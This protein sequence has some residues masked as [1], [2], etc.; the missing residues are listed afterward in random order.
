MH[1][2][3]SVN[4]GRWRYLLSMGAGG[5]LALAYPDYNISPA[6]WVAVGGL[7]YCA[8]GARVIQ[9]SACGLL[10]GL[11]YY[12]LS[13]PWIYTVLREYGPVPPVLSALLL[14]LLSLAAALFCAAFGALVAWIARRNTN[15]ALLA[16]PFLWVTLEFARTNLPDIGFPWNL[17]GYVAS[18]NLVLLQITSVTGIFGLSLLVGAYNSLFAWLLVSRGGETANVQ[19]PVAWKKG[20]ETRVPALIVWICATGALVATSFAGPLVPTE[21]PT[22]VAQL[23]Q[24]NLPQSLMY[25]PNWHA[26]HATDMEEIERLTASAGQKQPGLV[27]WP[28]VPAPFT[29]QDAGFAQRAAGIARASQ[30]AFL[31]GVVNWRPVGGKQE[32]FNAA[33][34]L[35][36]SGRQVFVYDK[37]HLVPFSEYVPWQG[38]LWFASD[39]T[40]LASDFSAGTKR[41]VGELPLDQGGRRFSVLIC[42]EAIFPN[43]VRRFVRNGAALLVNISNDGWF[44]R[45]SALGQ[46]LA[47]ARVRAVENRRWLLRA[48]NTGHTVA[49]DPY[50]RIVARLEPHRRG[51]LDAPYGFRS[52]V[53]LYTRGGD[54]VA[55][56]AVIA[57]L[58]AL[59]IAGVSRPSATQHK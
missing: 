54:W 59:L 11:I 40:G 56:S 26:I 52:D 47:M 50:G 35:D 43:E 14:G 6:G 18:E 36:A 33:A 7:V 5:A 1:G 41:S 15:V 25:E 55:W 3:T 34:V 8:I 4:S 30:S 37:I 13:L 42:Y 49:V 27:I 9:A 20:A 17:L 28:E 12:V 51:V 24:T 22:H 39:L 21:P 58:I 57:A 23:V 38:W 19:G 45:S 46:H 2:R 16:A 53:T 29:L 10:F 32:P 48:T 31:L 44:G